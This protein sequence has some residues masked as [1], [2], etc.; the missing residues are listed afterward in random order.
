MALSETHSHKTCNSRHS[1]LSKLWV[2]VAWSSRRKFNLTVSTETL[3]YQ[4][5]VNSGKTADGHLRSRGGL[6]DLWARPN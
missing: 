6:L 2:G 5:V 4:I 1:P 3:V